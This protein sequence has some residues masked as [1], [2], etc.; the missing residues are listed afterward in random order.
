MIES[1]SKKDLES[2]IDLYVNGRLTQEQV[3]ELW[4]E[5]IEDGYYLDYMKSVANLKAVIDEK[6]NSTKIAP[7]YTLRKIVN[8][9]SVAA[10]AIIIGV[11]GTLNYNSSNS[12]LTLTPL[13]KLNL[14]GIRG[15][16]DVPASTDNK[17]VKEAIELANNGNV[18]QAIVLLETELEKET[19]PNLIAETSLTLGSIQYNYGN[20]SAALASFELVIQQPGIEVLLLETGYWFLANTHTQLDN[21]TEAEVAF[22]NVYELDGAHSRL[23]KTNLEAIQNLK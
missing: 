12:T 23:A 17:I 1:N 9:G 22:K 2:K 11:L 4:A 19:S 18:E 10:V 15:D 8:Y 7:T 13:E 5:L 21:L 6:R 14:G 16:V 3:D 20:Y